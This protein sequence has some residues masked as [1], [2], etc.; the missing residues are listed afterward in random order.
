MYFELY[1]NCKVIV[2]NISER[3]LDEILNPES[4]IGLAVEQAQLVINEIEKM[5]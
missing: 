4:Y 1:L 3:N 5:R 2:E